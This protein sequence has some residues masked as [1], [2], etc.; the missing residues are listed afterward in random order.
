MHLSPE[1]RIRVAAPALK[2]G[3]EGKEEGLT[4]D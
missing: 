4:L 2:D 3:E 1:G